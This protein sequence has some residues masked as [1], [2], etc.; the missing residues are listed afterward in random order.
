[1]R[2][3]QSNQ[4]EERQNKPKPKS[5]IMNKSN[6][7]GSMY[8]FYQGKKNDIDLDLCLDKNVLSSKWVRKLNASVWRDADKLK[9][10]FENTS[11]EQKVFALPNNKYPLNAT[12]ETF[13]EICN[14]LLYLTN[15]TQ[16]HFIPQL[17]N[18]ISTVA[19]KMCVYWGHIK[20]NN[21]ATD[22]HNA[23]QIINKLASTINVLS[24]DQ[25][26]SVLDFLNEP[27]PQSVPSQIATWQIFLADP[28]YFKLASENFKSADSID[29][30]LK[31]FLLKGK[32]DKSE[33]LQ[34][35]DECVLQI[36]YPYLIEIKDT[37]D[38]P[39]ALK[40]A[41][42]FGK[43]GNFNNENFKEAI[44]CLQKAQPTTLPD[45][46]ELQLKPD[47][48]HQYNIMLLP[49]WSVEATSLGQMTNCCQ[50]IG[51][52]DIYGSIAARDGTLGGDKG[53]YVILSR[54][55]GGNN[56]GKFRQYENSRLKSLNSGYKIIGQCFAHI[57]EQGQSRTLVLDSVQLLRPEA[58]QKMAGLFIKELALKVCQQSEDIDRVTVGLGGGT[59]QIQDLEKLF[60]SEKLSI[61]ESYPDSRK[62]LVIFDRLTQLKMIDHI[63]RIEP[64]QK[65]NIEQLSYCE[66]KELLKELFSAQSGEISKLYGLDKLNLTTHQISSLYAIFQTPNLDNA[67][68][69]LLLSEQ[70]LKAY[71]T[72]M[73]WVSDLIDLKLDKINLLISDQAV[74]A[75]KTGS[76]WALALKGLSEKKIEL[77][78]S[79]QAL[80]VY[81]ILVVS[82]IA[83]K[84]LSEKEIEL[85]IS[86]RAVK[87]YEAGKFRPSDLK[88]LKPNTIEL[89]I[90]DQAVKALDKLNLTTHQISSLCSTF[91]ILN[92]DNAGIALLLSE[93]ALKAY[94]TKM[95]WVS[96]FIGLELDKIKLLISKQAV[97]AYKT[98]K[99]SAL[100]L[101]DLS[102]K[103]IELLI[104]KQAVEAYK[105]GRVSVSDLKTLEP[106]K[107]QLFLDDK[108]VDTKVLESYEFDFNVDAIGK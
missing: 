91:E 49:S 63:K 90:S 15:A 98:G 35:I 45:I 102:E 86:E 59:S 7:L 28:N 80:K 24:D 21:A 60:G 18:K 12:D 78:I 79:D 70:A 48:Y 46:G 54:E 95:V 57:Q 10:K 34:F 52:G 72:K 103:K 27:I 44:E 32:K 2:K 71:A 50:S 64:I 51:G 14:F 94:A 33:I 8:H 61:N 87:L 77:L 97:E 99:V 74:K 36:I 65:I 3:Q 56:D 68:I 106:D 62:Q 75:Y 20:Q 4:I 107:M 25:Y 104:S 30:K 85:L 83:L 31:D 105:T 11:I 19:H 9:E 1:M 26:T 88:G 43:E 39:A 40:M 89:L 55:K 81:K 101:N 73:V 6:F 42:Y 84:D 67:G 23:L 38:Y 76:V 47:K 13:Q 22:Q 37:P 96:D 16:N 66:L 82:A 17:E 100:A 29:E 93:Q 5:I 92:L 108:I 58:N 69:T 53:F 41:K